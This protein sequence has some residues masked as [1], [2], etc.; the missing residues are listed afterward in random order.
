VATEV[1]E[2]EKAAFFEWVTTNNYE[3]D[4]NEEYLNFAEGRQSI[5]T[6]TR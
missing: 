4:I 6:V 3:F 1:D 2:H 5:I